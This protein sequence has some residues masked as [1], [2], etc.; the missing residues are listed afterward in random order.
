VYSKYS[1]LTR[2][3]RNDDAIRRTQLRTDQASVSLRFAQECIQTEPTS[4]PEV[5]VVARG[6][7][8]T[9]QEMKKCCEIW[10]GTL[11]KFGVS[12]PIGER[13]ELKIA[14]AFEKF[15]GKRTAQAL[16]GARLEKPFDGFDPADNV[17]LDRIF[18]RRDGSDMVD[19]LVNLTL[20]RLA[21]QKK[22][23]QKT[24]L[25]IVEDSQEYVRDPNRISDIMRSIFPSYRKL[26]ST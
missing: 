25:R 13:D 4:L 21:E 8:L 14:R 12:R 7:T 26:K 23:R 5:P 2:S 24:K 10:V 3:P 16:Y 19:K 17:S 18:F 9:R 1:F 15:G 6:V 11:E 22:E 20:R